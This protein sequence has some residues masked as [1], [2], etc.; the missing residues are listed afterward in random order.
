VFSLNQFFQW[1]GKLAGIRWL[2]AQ[3]YNTIT[4]S[5]IRSGHQAGAVFLLSVADQWNFVV[6]AMHL[7]SDKIWNTVKL[8]VFIL[9]SDAVFVK[10]LELN[11]HFTYFYYK[12]KIIKDSNSLTRSLCNWSAEYPSIVI[13]NFDICRLN[14]IIHY[15]SDIIAKLCYKHAVLTD[16]PMR[17]R[18]C[19]PI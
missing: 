11:V 19:Q 6:L 3:P 4:H 8:W 17:M 18:I 12:M 7:R 15:S 13:K 9:P 1:L 14:D 2:F 16:Q 5:V 10:H